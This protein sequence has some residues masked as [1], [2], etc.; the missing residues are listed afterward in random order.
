VQRSAVLVQVQ[1]QVQV[2]QHSVRVAQDSRARC[3]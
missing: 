2:Q 1:A 3:G